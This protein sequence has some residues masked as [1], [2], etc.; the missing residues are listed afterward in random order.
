MIWNYFKEVYYE[1]VVESIIHVESRFSLIFFPC[2]F[3]ASSLFL[4]NHFEQFCF[5]CFTF[6]R[7][8]YIYQQCALAEINL[9]LK[10]DIYPGRRKYCALL[11]ETY[12]WLVTL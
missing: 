1:N 10:K 2:S 7:S 3:F 12:L 5:S 4:F 8:T 6:T 9:D 11:L